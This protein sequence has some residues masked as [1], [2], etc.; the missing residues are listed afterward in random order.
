MMLSFEQ[1]LGRFVV[2]LVV[3]AILGIE[4]ELVGKE[5]GVRTEMLVAGGASIF[6]MI[7]LILP[8]VAAANAHLAPD[9][10]TITSGFGIVANI[11][12]GIGFLGAGLILH[13]GDHIRNLTT[14][15]IVWMTAA[16]GI[17]AG[18]GLFEFAFATAVIVAVV[19]YALRALR[20]SEAS[21]K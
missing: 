15:A 18:L 8:Y 11:V 21:L 20:F 10:A 4:R 13:N 19:L 17:L 12:V 16:I 7:G 1:L 5:A 3:G 2:A 14:A 9:A 6:T